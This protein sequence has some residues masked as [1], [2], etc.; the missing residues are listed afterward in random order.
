[1][2]TVKAHP[3]AILSYIYPYLFVMIIPIARNLME[4]LLERKFTKLHLA[5]IVIVAA[6]CI[7]AVIKW[8]VCRIEI[9]DDRLVMKSGYII[10]YETVIK[11]R[12]VSCV[13]KVRT[14]LD[15]LAKSVTVQ[16]DSEAGRRGKPD[17]QVKI[18]ERDAARLLEFVNREK[19]N[20]T[21][22]I[23]LKK[24]ALAAAATSS[25]A[26]GALLA[27]PIVN[28]AGKLLNVGLA[29]LLFSRVNDASR[30]LG[31]VI[32]PIVN[33]VSIVFLALYLVSFLV[34]LVKSLSMKIEQTDNELSVALG[35]LSRRQ[36]HFKKV[37][38]NSVI[39]DQALIMRIVRRYLLK[40]SIAGYGGEKGEN[41]TLVPSIS[42][43]E[44]DA[45]LQSF[46]RFHRPTDRLIT[47][48]KSTEF[49]FVR[50]YL[51]LLLCVPV[52]SY[53]LC[54]L[55]PAFDNLIIFLAFVA[56]AVVV[57]AISLAEHNFR[58]GVLC[59]ERDFVFAHAVA[60]LS[61]REMFI[62]REKIGMIKIRR[63]PADF[64]HGTCNV[65]LT[66]RSESGERIRV[67]HIDYAKTKEYYGD[68][69]Q[70]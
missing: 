31:G 22:K 44:S 19:T 10:R 18:F 1:M 60:G 54:V 58:H 57:Y 69:R 34:G 5:E 17:F 66:E 2:K 55:F 56:A 33:A 59:F 20:I 13:T 14:P 16:V 27:A 50:W 67:K 41:Q 23:P 26:V 25:A 64:K 12:N 62:Y 6:V 21:L 53:V 4:L 15:L 40:V 47:A 65:T 68:K 7:N 49:R 3:L 29:E 70:H 43:G 45:F 61:V 8:L 46:F 51:L 37:S 36:T 38:V 24:I 48:E 28:K 9:W 30:H 32:P 11:K 52:A 39:L 63:Y 42:R 35:V